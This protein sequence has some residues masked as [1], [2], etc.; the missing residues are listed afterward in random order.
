MANKAH[1]KSHSSSVDLSIF[2]NDI[3]PYSSCRD[4]TS[5]ISIKRLLLALKYDTVLRPQKNL[6]NKQIFIN[7]MKELY[8]NRLIDDLYHFKQCHS[9]KLNEIMVYSV[10]KY[11]YRG[12]DLNDCE[13]ANRHYRVN[14]INHN[15]NDP[16]FAFYQDIIDAFHFYLYHLFDA[17]FRIKQA[18]QQQDGDI[19]EG[20]EDEDEYYDK[21]FE[22]RKRIIQNT[23]NKTQRFQRVSLQTASK[24]SID[25]Y[26]RQEE[27]KQ[28]VT[29]LDTVYDILLAMNS[30]KKEE[31]AT[32]SQF[33]L[34][35][36]YD[37][38]SVDMDLQINNGDGNIFQFI[39][40]DH[41]I[42]AL[43]LQFNKA[44]GNVSK[45]CCDTPCLHIKV[46]KYT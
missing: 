18:D 31:I 46:F 45:L 36:E 29:Y 16:L 15:N 5:C 34:V 26:P 25:T 11:K 43:K 12:C 19:K 7:F 10:E 39:N 20:D 17:G 3:K 1:T 44:E 2:L 42:N 4:F 35:E 33:I 30:I 21:E 6:Q 13:F 8:K 37:T 40:K 23:Q 9:D 38:E 22:E 24:F 41:I 32:L 27:K 14:N 28:G